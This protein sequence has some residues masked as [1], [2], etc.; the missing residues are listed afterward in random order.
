ML[1]GID[2]EIGEGCGLEIRRGC[3]EEDRHVDQRRDD[4]DV[5]FVVDLHFLR[6][7]DR[8]QAIGGDVSNHQ[9]VAV[10]PGAGHLLDRDDSGGAGLVVDE[11]AAA[12]AMSQ[13]LGKK[14]G[15][16]VGQTARR[17]R[18]ENSDRLRRIGNLCAR[19]GGDEEEAEGRHQ[20]PAEAPH[21]SSSRRRSRERALSAYRKIVG[22]GDGIAQASTGHVL[23]S[24]SMRGGAGKC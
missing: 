15:D 17:V 1:P 12:Q 18:H 14:P 19:V 8:R 4:L 23:R 22:S 21:L 3:E 13:L 7:Q 24:R 11:N 16:D 9:G 6:E 5:A 20:R 2:Q 10:G